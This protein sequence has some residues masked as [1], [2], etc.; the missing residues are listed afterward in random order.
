MNN[1]ESSQRLELYFRTRYRSI[2]SKLS[3]E[4][5]KSTAK[6]VYVDLCGHEEHYG[7]LRMTALLKS[8]NKSFL[9]V[10]NFSVVVGWNCFNR[11][12][13][14]IFFAGEYREG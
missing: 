14:D 4:R 13:A 5:R 9:L 1:V 12:G 3:L 8:F 10:L 2:F 7:V 6:I 11:A